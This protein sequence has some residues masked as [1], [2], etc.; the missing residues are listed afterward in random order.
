[1]PPRASEFSHLQ[2]AGCEVRQGKP[3]GNE[4]WA[5]QLSHPHWGQARIASLKQSPVIPKVL[6]QFDNRLED[7]E[8]ANGLLGQSSVHI[9]LNGEKHDVLRDRKRLL[10]FLN[11]AMGNDGLIAMDLTASRFWPRAALDE[12]LSH[13]ADLDIDSLF[14]VHAV[15]DTQTGKPN[16]YHTHGLAEIGFFDFDVVRPSEDLLSARCHDFARA[17]AFSIVEGKVQPTTP[18]AKVIST[19]PIRFVEVTEF[20]RRASKAD[21]AMR[22]TDEFHNRNRAVLCDPVTGGFLSKIFGSTPR[23]NQIL[24]APQGDFMVFFPTQSTRLMARRAR[25]TY[26]YFRQ[27]VAEFAELKAKAIVKLGYRVDGGEPDD[28]EHMW[29]EVHALNDETIDA[30]LVNNPRHVSTLKQGQRLLHP[31]QQLTDWMLMLP[32]G[33]VNPRDAHSART[34]RAHRQEILKQLRVHS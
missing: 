14:T 10:R 20:N 1:M 11:A 6:L 23:P 18:I 28:L 9:E 31:V 15:T 12:E 27:L 19:G 29:F 17:V 8:K 3:S 26:S 34:A 5:L 4:A 16:W 30:T 32:T 7:S 33:T 24:S 22:D 2:S 21:R 25:Q 13:D